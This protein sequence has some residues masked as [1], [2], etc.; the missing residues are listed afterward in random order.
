MCQD[1]QTGF[2]HRTLRERSTQILERR[3]VPC[4]Q[5]EEVIL[6]CLELDGAIGSNDKPARVLKHRRTVCGFEDV[7]THVRLRCGAE[8]AGDGKHVG[9]RVVLGVGHHSIRKWIAELSRGIVL[10]DDATRQVAILVIRAGFLL[11]AGGA[12]ED[13]EGARAASTDEAG[14]IEAVSKGDVSPAAGAVS[15][16]FAG[17]VRRWRWIQCL[18]CRSRMNSDERECDQ[19]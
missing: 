4:H 14:V 16:G 10:V 8:I 17:I 13:I 2:F 6:T 5:L 3:R 11:V 7:L 19:G 12:V 18:L 15:D 1:G 9:D